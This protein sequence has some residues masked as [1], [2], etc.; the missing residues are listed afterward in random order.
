MAEVTSESLAARLPAVEA[1]LAE[2]KRNLV[3]AKQK[4]WRKVVGISSENKFT[5]PMRVEIEAVSD[6]ER[7]A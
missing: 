7:Q 3:S 1:E 2:Q 4:D 6:A 5:R